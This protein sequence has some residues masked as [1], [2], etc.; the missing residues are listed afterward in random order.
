MGLAVETPGKTNNTAAN[1]TAV[2]IGS[3]LIDDLLGFSRLCGPAPHRITA[4]PLKEGL[5]SDHYRAS[6]M[7][8][9]GPVATQEK[10]HC[11]QGSQYGLVSGQS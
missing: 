9:Q 11:F 5:D 3:A 10:H 1:D 2:N 8:V 4:P 6:P 7:G